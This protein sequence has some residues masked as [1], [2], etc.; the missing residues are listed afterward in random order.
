MSVS[1]REI[2]ERLGEDLTGEAKDCQCNGCK[3]DK[4]AMELAIS[5]LEKLF[6]PQLTEEEVEKVIEDF[7]NNFN[8]PDASPKEYRQRLASALIGKCGGKELEKAGVHICL[9]C[10]QPFLSIGV[11]L[12]QGHIIECEHIFEKNNTSINGDYVCSKCGKVEKQM[13]FKAT[14]TFSGEV[15]DKTKSVGCNTCEY[16]E[17]ICITPCTY[18]KKPTEQKEYCECKECEPIY[19]GASGKQFCINCGNKPKPIPAEKKEEKRFGDIC[20]NCGCEKI[21]HNCPEC[22]M[23]QPEPKPKDRI[24][25]GDTEKIVLQT[26]REYGNTDSIWDILEILAERIDNRHINK[27]S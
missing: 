20:N 5:K 11:K 21:L 7:D 24:E 19:S 14:P 2:I 6:P 10:G 25:L 26:N 13:Q 9:K 17:R 22:G 12:C 3:E 16:E 8:D 23:K 1:V 4:E 27:E 15:I 18:K